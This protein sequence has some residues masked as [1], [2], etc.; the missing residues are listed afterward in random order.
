MR[1]RRTAPIVLVVVVSIAG[2]ASSGGKA[3]I[4]PTPSTVSSAPPPSL[5]ASTPASSSAALTTTTPRSTA[6]APASVAPSTPARATSSAPVVQAFTTTCTRLSVRVIPGGAVRGAEIAGIQYVNDGTRTCRIT[7][8]PTA[9]LL[10]DGKAIG[11]RSTPLPRQATPFTLAPGE[12]GESLM[13]DF[14]TCNAP[15]SDSVMLTMP[16]RAGSTPEPVL[17]PAR[18]RACELRTPPVGAPS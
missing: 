7:G 18:L 3:S 4:S 9:Q 10:R 14:S 1:L 15:L 13:Q 11:T 5:P 8:F 12:V 17:R 2:C 16:A 6:A